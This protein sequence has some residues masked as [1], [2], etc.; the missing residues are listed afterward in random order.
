MLMCMAEYQAGLDIGSTTIKMVVLKDGE[1]VL[2]KYKRHCADVEGL[3]LHYLEEMEKLTG[4][5]PLPLHLTG[6]V[7]L[8]I[9]ETYQLPFVQEV[10]A[11]TRYVHRYYPGLSSM[12]DIGGEDAKV[13]FWGEGKATDL[14]MNGN[15]AGGTGAFIDQMAALLGVD[16]DEMGRIAM[17]STRLYPIAS[18]C[19]VFCKTD[20][21]NLLARGA[22][23][24]DIA[25]S[26]FHAVA[27]QTVTTLAHGRD[28]TA[29]VLLCGGPLS[30]LPALRQ[31]FAEYLGMVQERDFVLPGQGQLIPAWGAA[32]SEEGMVQP[33]ALKQQI[34]EKREQLAAGGFAHTSPLFADEEEYRRWKEGHDNCRLPREGMKAGSQDCYIGIDS[35]STT[36][37]L[38]ALSDAGRALYTYYRYND[39]DP[40]GAVKEALQGMQE[41][42]RRHGTELRIRGGCST[43]YGE[44]LIKAAFH[45]DAGIIETMAHYMAARQLQP[46][47][48]F[49][50][51]IGGQDMKAVFIKEGVI[52]RIEINEACS[53]GCGS[54]ISTFAQSLHISL[55]DF[56]R[57]AC[58]ATAPCDL[59]T[60]C[61]VF[62]NSRVKQVLRQ[63][64]TRADIAA[65]L[66]CSVVRN[67]LYKV[68]R[69]R[70]VEELGRHIVVQGGAMRNDAIVRS[71][72]KLAKVEV[73]RSDSPELMGALGCALYARQLQPGGAVPLDELASR[74]VGKTRLLHC[75]GCENRCGITCYDF[76]KGH[77]YFSGNRC[78]KVFSN[79]LGS[80][81][82]G[83]DSYSIKRSLLFD[84]ESN[85]DN[86]RWVL[87]IPRALNMYEEY[88][89]W[90][91]LFT[92][93]GIGVRLS[94]PSSHAL[95][96]KSAGKVM[97]DNICFPAKL[98]HGHISDLARQG[99]SR[100]FMPFVLHEKAAKGQLNSFN[101]PIVTGYSAVVQSVQPEIPLDAPS[102]SFHDS[103]LLQRQCM[104]Y[105]SGLGAQAG[106]ARK[107]FGAAWEEYAR[108]GRQLAKANQELLEEALAKGQKVIVLAG[109]P[110]HADMFIQHKI[111]EMITSMGITVI[112]E[113]IAREGDIPVSSGAYL[114]QWSYPN[115]I[116]RVAHWIASQPWDVQFVQLTS[117]GCGPDAILTDAVNGIL[118]KSGRNLTL[119]KIDDVSNM[120][121]VRLRVRSLVESL[122]LSGGK[123]KPMASQRIATPPYTR[124]ER[125]RK[126]LAPFFSE[127]ISPLL[128][129][130]MKRAGYE[131]EILPPSDAESVEWGL[132]CANNEICYPATLIVGDYIKAFRQGKYDPDSCCVAI[133]QTGGQCRASNYLPLIRKALVENGYTNT[134][135]LALSF[136]TGIDNQQPAFR[137]NWV[138]MAGL[139]LATL[140]YAD[141]IARFYHA[142]VVRE[143][144]A[145][146]AVRLRER[147][148]RRVQPLLEKG[149]KKQVYAL[150][151]EAASE[152]REICRPVACPC[153]GIVGEIYLKFNPFAQKNIIRWLTERGIEV[154]PPALTPFFTQSFVNLKAR[155]QSHVARRKMPDAL[156]DWAQN[157]VSGQIRKAND[158]ASPFPWFTPIEDTQELA[159]HGSKVINLNAQ[160][161][162]GWL[163]PAEILSYVQRGVTHVISLQPFGCIA[164]HIVQKGIENKLK[165]LCPE[166][167]LLSL[168]FD[169]SVSDVN[170]LNRLLL[171]IE[172]LTNHERP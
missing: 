98:T 147:Y 78:E 21:Q 24:A 169:S 31:A 122:K 110:Y 77:R 130:L 64:A 14:R 38:V 139:C 107:A 136:G 17:E 18:R 127:Y 44:D 23:K 1:P 7:A 57:E 142:S 129:A 50:L 168:D 88:P 138:R 124:K 160:F 170:I 3:L 126:L 49:I 51:D 87:G 20:I 47:V 72:E 2:S 63:G 159:I 116:M 69:L 53:S 30:Y 171:F 152:F 86:P 102:I 84:R 65:G 26:I 141:C 40:V 79:S 163:I 133:T 101:C 119:L 46:E 167:N 29:P 71:F 112:N 80:S 67:C 113:D 165:A 153:V 28:I 75:G 34:L 83:K 6:S 93:C 99:V 52:T 58:F 146:M 148:L 162:E 172:N 27:V 81:G 10:V 60:R 25:A 37:K 150:I 90:H 62:M 32:L 149:D 12:I 131:V 144:G 22:G 143:K 8:G 108:Y 82:K 157:L 35:G 66:S 95:Y 74:A 33:G 91:T 156:L 5:A 154:L 13:V 115:R 61:T 104:E 158:L 11:A 92:Q 36:T 89:F 135:V 85:V 73:T 15:C 164:N 155:W 39:G 132:K 128:P 121:S 106:V 118:R 166:L 105:L 19:G 56:T 4:G 48:S 134:P 103:A 68:L 76:G 45:L 161:G 54:F 120:G 16:V 151:G 109:R 140:L 9:A 125:G 43:G 145:G 100:I 97:S 59:G 42:C 70:N 94:A 55:E 41:E 114:S 96:E 137:I 123:S 111:A 117:F